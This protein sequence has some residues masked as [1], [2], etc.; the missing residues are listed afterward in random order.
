MSTH[1]KH[2]DQRVVIHEGKKHDTLDA[3]DSTAVKSAQGFHTGQAAQLRWQGLQLIDVEAEPRQPREPA[4]AARDAAEVV[5]V[6][7]PAEQQ[8]ELET[9]STV[10]QA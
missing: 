3:G 7:R 8:C 9:S 4:E 6:Q 10:W 2:A 5:A 1:A